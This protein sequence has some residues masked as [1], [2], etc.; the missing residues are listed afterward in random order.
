TPVVNVEGSIIAEVK[1][2]LSSAQLRQ[3]RAASAAGKGVTLKI[4]TR[5]I[6]YEPKLPEFAM[7]NFEGNGFALGPAA[8]KSDAE[9]VKTLLWELY[10]LETSEAG[11]GV[12]PE[13]ASSMQAVLK[14]EYEAAKAFSERVFTKSFS[15]VRK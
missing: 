11:R 6:Q 4:G 10:R 7:T 5:M 8:L 15:N 2:I 9:L 3:I 12:L 13:G 14:A 1:Q